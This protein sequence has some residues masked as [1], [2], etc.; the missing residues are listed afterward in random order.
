[1]L[2]HGR[3][4]NNNKPLFKNWTLLKRPKHGLPIPLTDIGGSGVHASGKSL[5]DDRNIGR[6]GE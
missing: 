6:D 3:P 5:P 2:D 4:A 1:M